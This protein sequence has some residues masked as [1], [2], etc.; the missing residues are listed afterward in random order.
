MESPSQSLK[1]F[2]L[3]L[4]KVNFIL[5]VW[6]TK[7]HICLVL[8]NTKINRKVQSYSPKLYPCQINLHYQFYYNENYL[9][10]HLHMNWGIHRPAMNKCCSQTTSRKGEWKGSVENFYRQAPT[11]LPTPSPLQVNS[12]HLRVE[13]EICLIF[14]FHLLPLLMQIIMTKLILARTV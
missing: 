10:F 13:L 4:K 8:F 5:K 6:H 14:G 12:T 2:V 11:Q 3:F 7:K 9:H 1:F